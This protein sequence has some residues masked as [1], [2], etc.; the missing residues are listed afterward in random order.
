VDK[1]AKVWAANTGQ[2]LL[3][4]TGHEGG[5][6][7]ASYSAAGQRIVTGGPIA[8]LW[9]AN[10]GQELMTL[11]GHDSTVNSAVY[12]TDGQWIV[13]AGDKTAK[14]WDAETGQELLTLKGHDSSVN[15]VAYSPDGQRIAAA[16]GDS[17]VQ[18][19]T[20]DMDE[21]LEIAKSRVTRQLTAEEKEKY[22]VPD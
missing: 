15:S 11:T 13:T 9:D 6:R 7:S 20:T 16:G 5:V 4:L 2:E 1:T 21:L 10:T 14:V 12:S 17:I 22:G 3:T 18:I 19:Y 8:R